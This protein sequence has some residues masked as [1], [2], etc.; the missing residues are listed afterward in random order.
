MR[1]IIDFHAPQNGAR[2]TRPRCCALARTLLRQ[3]G[4]H[5]VHMAVSGRH[6]A[7]VDML[8]H[9]LR[10]PA[11][12][13]PFPRLC[14]ARRHQ[15]RRRRLAP[16]MPRAALRGRRRQRPWRA[17]MPGLAGARRVLRGA[18]LLLA[19]ARPTRSRTRCSRQCRCATSA[20]RR[21]HR[22]RRLAGA[23]KG[24]EQGVERGVGSCV[25]CAEPCGHDGAAAQRRRF[26]TQADA[27]AGVAAAAGT[28]G[29]RGLQR[30]A[31]AELERHYAVELVVT[32][33]A[34][35]DAALQRFPARRRLL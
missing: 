20:R 33:G 29:H 16:R 22:R 21:R 31:A 12:G 25:A 13:R 6:P 9:V 11:A 3:P 2:K 32:P 4:A 23:G 1:L 8:R 30:R 28:F 26:A 18:A 15:R 10:R 14:P 5:E 7:D 27:G 19:P 35:P 34:T 17:P 24:I